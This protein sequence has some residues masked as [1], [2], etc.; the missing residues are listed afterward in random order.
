[1]FQLGT[2]YVILK[3]N[4]YNL[5][6]PKIRFYFPFNMERKVPHLRLEYRV[7]GGGEAGAAV[8][9]VLILTLTWV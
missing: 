3:F 9:P 6:K 5:L 7:A 2:K 1:M 8:A 4:A